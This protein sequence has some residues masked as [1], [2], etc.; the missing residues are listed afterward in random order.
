MMKRNFRQREGISRVFEAVREEC[1][2]SES[3]EFVLLSAQR[4]PALYKNFEE[5]FLS[6]E[7]CSRRVRRLAAFYGILEG[8]LQQPVSTKVVT[9]AR[10]LAKSLE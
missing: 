2:D 7:H 1:L 10:T 5:H 9:M 8:E 4:N 3:L 6:C